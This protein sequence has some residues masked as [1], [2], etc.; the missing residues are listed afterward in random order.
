MI[1][2]NL[3]PLMKQYY[4]VKQQY[5]DTLVLFQVGDF[6]ELFFDDAKTAAA[7]LGIALTKRGK[8]ANG[9]PIPLCGV[10]VHTLDHYLTKL[11]KGGFKVALCDQLEEAQPGKMVERGVTRVLTPGTLTEA[12]LLDEKSA[13]FL[14]SFFPLEQSWG[15]LFGE[16][17]TAQLFGTVVQGASEKMLESELIR[18]FPDEVLLPTSKQGKQ[19]QAYF[20]QQ[21]YFTS[22]VDHGTDHNGAVGWLEQFNADAR[23]QVQH[24]ESLRLA[25][26]NFYTYVRKTQQASLAQFTSLQWYK[27][28]DFVLLDIATQRNLE[29]VKNNHDCGRQHTLYAA[30]DGAVTGMGSRMIKKWLLRP[31]VKAEAIT[32]RHDAVQACV[33]N[34]AVTQQLKEL[35]KEIGDLERVVGRIALRRG[36]LGDYVQL[37]QALQRIPHLKSLLQGHKVQLLLTITDHLSDFSL[38]SQRL[39]QALNDDLAKPWIIKQGFDER[40]DRVR[41]LVEQGASKVVAL[42]QEEIEAT[43]ITSLKIRFNNV[44][45]Y[46][47]EITKANYDAI[48][49]RYIRRQTLVG[50]E[51]FTTPALQQLEHEIATAHRDITVV[52]QAIFDEL[53]TEVAR[54]VTQLRKVAYV[55]SHLDAL[56]SFATIAAEHGYVRP[57]LT[58]TRD[59]TIR[60]GRHPVV[61]R[62]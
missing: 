3:T 21:G 15:L 39:L 18:F 14:F 48:P 4:A 20:K 42:E 46:Y 2:D 38:L 28:D 7:F 1:A 32:Q 8:S 23:T 57:R 37:G 26:I 16:L 5:P 50:R 34:V 35:L 29:I 9:D 27:P 52:E 30:L 25:L 61:E 19:F 41:D 31:L 53:K 58:T 11:V 17:M 6:Y 12:T 22:L 43:G 36:T 55:L 33:E 54:H 44:H 59:I 40:L 60:G 45:G 56:L 49:E 62:T 51:R 47:I 10:P 13:S 24:H